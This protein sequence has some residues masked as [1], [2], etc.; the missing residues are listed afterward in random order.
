MYFLYQTSDINHTGQS[1]TAENEICFFFK[2]YIYHRCDLVKD[3]VV[4][5]RV[6]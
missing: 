1:V 6:K 4:A 2:K 5:E 3:S